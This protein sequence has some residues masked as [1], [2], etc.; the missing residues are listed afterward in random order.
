MCKTHQTYT[1]LN[2]TQARRQGFGSGVQTNRPRAGE[3]PPIRAVSGRG[4]VAGPWDAP[5]A[6][7]AR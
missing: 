3:S 6:E 1:E 4:Y 5:R 7:K 2:V